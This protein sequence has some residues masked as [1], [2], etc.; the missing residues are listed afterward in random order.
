MLGAVPEDE[1]LFTRGEHPDA[2][3]AMVFV[4][5]DVVGFGVFAL[6]GEGF[7]VRLG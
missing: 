7:N 3:A 5:A 4:P 1:G 6:V 2:E